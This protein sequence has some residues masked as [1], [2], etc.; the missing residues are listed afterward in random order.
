M[1]AYY[2][3]FSAP[4]ALTRIGPDLSHPLTDPELEA[5][6]E[7]RLGTLAGVVDLTKV[8]I[9][10]THGVA[11]LSGSVPSEELKSA[12]VNFADNTIGVRGVEDGL[13]VLGL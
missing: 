7:R 11:S 13:T 1:G 6:I 10:V 2:E 12:L 4:Y 9:S 5:A 3:T 8:Q